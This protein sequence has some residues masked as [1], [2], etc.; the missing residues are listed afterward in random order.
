MP[1]RDYQLEA[2][3]YVGDVEGG[4]CI[5]AGT[6]ARTGTHIVIRQESGCGFDRLVRLAGWHDP[7]SLGALEDARWPLG[8]SSPDQQCFSTC[9]STRDATALAV[10]TGVRDEN[11]NPGH[12]EHLRDYLLRLGDVMENRCL[13]DCVEGRV[14]IR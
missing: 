2:I 1:W 3:G 13:D 11:G 8:T 7:A 4:E 12:S 10:D 6:S 9:G 14:P 5:G